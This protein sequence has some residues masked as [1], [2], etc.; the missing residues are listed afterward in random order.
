M[1]SAHAA[2]GFKKRIRWRRG[3]SLLLFI[4]FANTALAFLAYKATT[5]T[6][7]S[8]SHPIVFYATQS[9]HDL[10]LLFCQAIRSAEHALYASFYGITDK[11]ILALLSQRCLSGIS[12]SIDYDPRASLSLARFLP[13]SASL[14]PL[15]GSGLMHRKILAIDNTTVF[16]GSANLTPP[17]LR[18]HSNFVLGLFAPGLAQFVS[19]PDASSY[20]FSVHAQNAEYYVLPDKE[21]RALD[22]L[23]SAFQHA[24]QS[25]RIA[26]F[27]FTHPQIA[28]A[29]IHAA[30]RGIKVDAIVDHYSGR[31]ASKKCV[32]QL[33][34]ENIHVLLGQGQQLLHHKWAI[35]DEDT[36]IMG[37]ANWTKAAFSKNADYLLVLAPLTS[38][39]TAFINDLWHTL[40]LEAG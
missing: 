23:L 27:T 25:I 13:A 38:D 26:M 6:L 15:Q 9:R 37:S 20:N 21:N 4:L 17:S 7:P 28:A 1:R 24:K 8:P 11:E 5:P 18:H 19:K 29:L 33:R 40:E 34:K 39:Q 16:L 36:F 35:I 14:T 3:Y 2:K 32:E 10:K 31:G 22:R 30:Q 12:V